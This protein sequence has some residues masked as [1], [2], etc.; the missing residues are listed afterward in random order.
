MKNFNPSSTEPL[1]E[2]QI[3]LI[4]QQKYNQQRRIRHMKYLLKQRHSGAKLIS[5]IEK[6]EQR[7]E[8]LREI[9]DERE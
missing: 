3:K 5:Y 4:L 7:L 6:L 9:R 1:S 8:L 2:R